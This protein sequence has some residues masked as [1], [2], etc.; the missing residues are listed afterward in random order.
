MRD[1]LYIPLGG[2]RKG[3]VRTY[4]NL[5]LV[6][7]IGGLWHG[8]NLKFVLWGALHG[9]YLVIDKLFKSIFGK[10]ERLRPLKIF[11][12]FNVVAFT[13]IVFRADSLTTANEIL[14]QI[15]TN[16]N[17]I[18]IGEYLVAYWQIVA[19]MV[20]TYIIHWLPDGWKNWYRGRF[21]VMPMWL[22]VA[23][24]VVTVFVLVQF[25]QSGLQPFIYFQF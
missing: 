11:L 3:R 10:N 21:V 5:F 9:L 25:S 23:L 13:W 7:L 8:A 24:T 22:Q 15:F 4:I 14:N 6:M 1:Y 20:A 16:F 2:N 19:V 17:A 18:H 12:T